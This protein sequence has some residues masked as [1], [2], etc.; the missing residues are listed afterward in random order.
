M[1]CSVDKL[2]RLHDEFDL[3]NAAASKF[4]VA[5]EL[6]CADDVAL[7]AP[8][9]ARNFIQQIGR[10]ASG[11]NERLMLPQE[12]VSQLTAAADSA[13]LDQRKTF[14]G[15]AESG[16]IIFHALERAGQWPCRAF[17]SQTQIDAEKRASRMPGRKCF[18]DSFS[19]P[20]KEFV[21]GNVCCELAFFTVEKEKINIRAVVQFAAAE[22]AQRKDGEFR[23]GRTVLF[24]QFR[25]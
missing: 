1:P 24:P 16:I 21:I 7:D 2:E 5:F 25:V 23:L 17:R 15:F 18:E 19:Q 20:V 14:P 4:H 13:R 9:N 6:V 8:L 22:F 10:C 11:I 3:A 12:F